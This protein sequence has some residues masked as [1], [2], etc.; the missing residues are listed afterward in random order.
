[1]DI[2]TTAGIRRRRRIDEMAIAVAIDRRRRHIADVAKPMNRRHDG[3]HAHHR[4]TQGAD[5]RARRL[6]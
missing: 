3:A 6:R 2:S 4:R 5:H 1:M